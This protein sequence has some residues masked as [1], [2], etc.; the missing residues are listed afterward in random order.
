MGGGLAEDDENELVELG[1]LLLLGERDVEGGEDEVVE[2]LLGRGVG[3]ELVEDELVVS[4]MYL[5][6]EE[7]FGGDEVSIIA[8][9]RRYAGA[10]LSR[11]LMGR[12]EIDDDEYD[13]SLNDMR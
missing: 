11:A 12:T 2:L 13:W 3:D 10:E 6:F 4:S 1:A 8:H 7:D 9:L 5:R